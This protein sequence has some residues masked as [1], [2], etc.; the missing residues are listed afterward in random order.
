MALNMK[1]KIIIYKK[2]C[3]RCGICV[4]FCPKKALDVDQ[5]G[6]PFLCNDEAC[7]ECGLCELRC[8]DF[9]VVLETIESHH[10]NVEVK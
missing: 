3:K 4:A 9:A 6:Y 2:W 10:T 8:P 1:A 5:E 7:T